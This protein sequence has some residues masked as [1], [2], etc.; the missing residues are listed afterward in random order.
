M[1]TVIVF[2]TVSPVEKLAV[3][4]ANCASKKAKASKLS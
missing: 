4:M 2:Y 3:K 1:I